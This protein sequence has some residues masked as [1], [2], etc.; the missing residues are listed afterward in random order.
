[1]ITAAFPEQNRGLYSCS[2]IAAAIWA[3]L[4]SEF[5]GLPFV[6][7]DLADVA[8]RR[9]KLLELG[10]DI[11]KPASMN[12]GAILRPM[13]GFTSIG[14]TCSNFGCN[15]GSSGLHRLASEAN[16][17]VKPTGRDTPTLGRCQAAL[18]V[19]KCSLSG[20]REMRMARCRL[21]SGAH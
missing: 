11:D 5:I 4:V 12:I 20:N 14:Q 10:V 7:K 16:A 8:S 17:G 19:S 3:V 2:Y 15:I 6:P 13:N 1:M 18:R 9:R 21:A